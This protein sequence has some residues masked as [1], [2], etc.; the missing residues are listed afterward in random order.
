MG[1]R[2][3]NQ[4]VHVD[5]YPFKLFNRI[6]TSL[7]VFWRGLVCG[8]P[9]CCILFFLQYSGLKGFCRYASVVAHH[10]FVPCPKCVKRGDLFV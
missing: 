5:Y 9:V 1:F 2:F 8:F 10:G 3:L 7:R 6:P 4:Y